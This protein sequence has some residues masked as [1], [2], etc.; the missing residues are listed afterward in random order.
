MFNVAKIQRIGNI[1]EMTHP[2]GAE[3][4]HE[5]AAGHESGSCKQDL[6]HNCFQG[7]K[8]LICRPIG[9]GMYF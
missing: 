4:I 7:H 5:F 8:H 9:L 2:M 1:H 3:Q 6:K